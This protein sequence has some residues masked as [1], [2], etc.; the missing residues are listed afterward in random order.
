[1]KHTIF[2]DQK[3]IRKSSGKIVARKF[4]V[5]VCERINTLSIKKCF[6]GRT[7]NDS[8]SATFP[9]SRR[10]FYITKRPRKLRGEG[11]LY[12]QG[13]SY[14]SLRVSLWR[15]LS[16]PSWFTRSF[17]YSEYMRTTLEKIS[18]DYLTCRSSNAFLI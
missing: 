10:I 3:Y 2:L 5:C 16:L 14:I 15:P 18:S 6:V 12:S 11:Q 9:R 4:C 1:M 7:V 17:R 13:S 8:K